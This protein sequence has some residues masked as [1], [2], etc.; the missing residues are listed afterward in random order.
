MGISVKPAA[1]SGLRLSSYTD[2]NR[3]RRNSRCTR[4]GNIAG[5]IWETAAFLCSSMGTVF[6]SQ[7][8]RGTA[9]VSAIAADGE[10]LN[11]AYIQAWE[12]L[13]DALRR[14]IATGSTESGAKRDLCDAIVDKAISV[15]LVLAADTRRGLPQILVAAAELDLPA[16]LL[17]RDID[18]QRSRPV[19]PWPPTRRALSE[20][21]TLYASRV[22][23]LLERTIETIK[24]RSSDVSRIFGPATLVGSKPA[25]DSPSRKSGSGAKALGVKKA[26]VHLWPEGPPDGLS[27]KDRNNQVRNY[28]T[29]KKLSVPTD[30]ARAIQRALRELDRR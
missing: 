23:H 2:S 18:W 9:A 25:Q 20:P 21:I 10:D 7:N 3:L 13:A 4:N 15:Q 8:S 6:I 12:T 29:E 24:V 1:I 17:P 22:A 19:K 16:C 11:L 26:M 14:L 27:A 5:F 30:L 28:L